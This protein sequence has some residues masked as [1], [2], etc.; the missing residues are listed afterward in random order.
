MSA[1]SKSASSLR[2]LPQT[3]EFSVELLVVGGAVGKDIAVGATGL[4]FVQIGSSIANDM[5]PLRCF[6]GVM[7]P[8]R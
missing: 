3:I 2:T 6:F 8:R 4:G 5:P 7:L 1:D